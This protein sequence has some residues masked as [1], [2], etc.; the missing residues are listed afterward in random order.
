MKVLTIGITTREEQK[1]RTLA[2]ARG[3]LSRRRDDPKVWFSSIESY[4][5]YRVE[6]GT[7]KI[8]A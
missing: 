2:I 5:A 3:E 7:A 6:Y 1:A 8:A 4:D